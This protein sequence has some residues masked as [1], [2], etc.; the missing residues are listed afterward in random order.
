LKYCLDELNFRIKITG[1]S[2]RF[3]GKK[4]LS[5]KFDASTYPLVG[6]IFEN[7]GLGFESEENV[8]SSAVALSHPLE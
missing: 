1:R 3:P 6:N 4:S 5:A 2:P 7:R 8:K